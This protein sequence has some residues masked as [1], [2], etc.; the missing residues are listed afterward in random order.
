[1]YLF[2]IYGGKKINIKY[3]HQIIYVQCIDNNEF[4]GKYKRSL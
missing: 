1:M 2:L 3:V 4:Q